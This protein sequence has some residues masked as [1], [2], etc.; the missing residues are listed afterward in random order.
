MSAI[1]PVK[2]SDVELLAQADRVRRSVVRVAMRNKAGHIAP[3]LSCIDIIVSLYGR[4]MS[5]RPGAPEWPERDRMIFSKAHGGYGLY[6]LLAEYGAIPAAEWEGYYTSASS[7]TGCVERRPEYGIEAG[8]GSLGHGLPISVGL[9]DGARRLGLPWHTFCL[10]GDGE[11]QE[12]TTWE[13]IQYAVRHRVD[14][15]T[16][17]VDR[18]GLQA[19]DRLDNVLDREDGDLLRR[20]SGFGLNPVEV[21]GHDIPA[22]C[23]NLAAGKQCRQGIPSVTIARTIKGY[24]LRCMEGISKFHFRLPTEEELAAGGR[25]AP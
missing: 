14:A 12:G 17:I 15:L 22:L 13:A 3:S 6:A 5:W 19:M 20:L 9:A 7:L 21:D 10:V 2:A 4:V 18:N 16:I 8:C 1:E 11:L 23:R 24:G 25:A